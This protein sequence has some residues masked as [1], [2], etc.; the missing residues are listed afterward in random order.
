MI[1]ARSALL[2]IALAV[3]HVHATLLE[4]LR[5]QHAGI[6]PELDGEVSKRQE[7]RHRCDQLTDTA[8][9][10]ERQFSHLTVINPI[11]YRF[12]LYSFI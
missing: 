4:R 7:S 12:I 8:K 5:S 9:V 11:V 1:V 2:E 10:L 3:R 6:L